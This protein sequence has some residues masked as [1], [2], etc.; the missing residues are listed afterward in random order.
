MK[1]KKI[2][3][4]LIP[5]LVISFIIP[6]I[7]EYFIY[8]NHVYSVL[9]NSDWSS[10]LGSYISGLI[11]GIGTLVAVFISINETR[12]VQYKSDK[13]RDY[14]ERK[15]FSDEIIVYVSKYITDINKYFYNCKTAKTNKENLQI[16]KIELNDL[17]CKINELNETLPKISSDTDQMIKLSLEK[18]SLEKK[19]SILIYKIKDIERE[20]ELYRADRTIA[21]ECYYILNIKLKDMP[22]ANSVISQLEYIHRQLFDQNY[23]WISKE[24]DKLITMTV[25]FIDNYC[26]ETYK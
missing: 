9:D 11:G 13:D 17:Q 5:T 16:K 14:N 10:F 21:I 3:L 25:S 1:N 2:V 8:R 24:T 7:L 20:I 26:S 23:E 15:K 4:F 18:E 22:S 19:E 6:F 12:K